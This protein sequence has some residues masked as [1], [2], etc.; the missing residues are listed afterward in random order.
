[1]KNTRDQG[2]TL[3]EVLI[4]GTII[5]LVL[6]SLLGSIAFGLNG[7]KYAAGHQQAVFHARELME[8]IRERQLASAVITPPNPGFADP[9][10]ARIPLNAPPFENDFPADTG[11]TRR[12]ETRRLSTDPTNYHS[13]LYEIKI[14]VFWKV[15]SRE[16]SFRLSGLYRVP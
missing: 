14:T 3:L 10:T 7:T 8:L 5:L 11:Y 13:K 16:N 15:K 2:V 12:I 6:L 1:M 4:A 9:S